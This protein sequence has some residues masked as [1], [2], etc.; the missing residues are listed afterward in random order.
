ML[1]WLFKWA[2][3]LALLA[4]ALCAA[5]LLATNAIV[6]GVIQHQIRARCG[7]DARLGRVSV[8]VFTPAL[9]VEGLRIYHSA[10]FGGALLLDAPEVHV[11]Y[12]RGSLSGP[13]LRLKLVRL[14]I[15]E[16]NVIRSNAGRTNLLQLDWKKPI[17]ALKQTHPKPF[18]E[19]EVLNL[20]L[21]RVRFL[22]LEQPHRNREFRADLENQI[23]RNIKSVDDL[24]GVLFLLWLRTSEETA[25]GG[26]RPKSAP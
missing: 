19:I 20:S 13:K 11:E 7:L 12:D 15:A 25:H 5:L 4:I 9:D 2:F 6:K 18:P 16:L 26:A 17:R 23:F 8:R 10:E 21:G 14:R 1:K 22:D 3:R 24:R